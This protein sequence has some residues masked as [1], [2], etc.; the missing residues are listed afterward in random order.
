MNALTPLALTSE[1]MLRTINAGDFA[2][3][4]DLA[5]KSGRDKRHI[6]RDLAILE[7]GGL[8]LKADGG[9]P[10][11][12]DAG[13]DQL[14][15]IERANTPLVLHDQ[16][17]PDP[18]NPRRVFHPEAL[19]ALAESIYD[20][21]K[22]TLLQPPVIR[23][24]EGGPKPYRLVAGERRW[25]AIG[26]LI[27]DGRWPATTPVPVSIRPMSDEEAAILALVENMQREDLSPVDEAMTFEHLAET[28]G[29]S[30][31]DIAKHIKR[32]PEYVQQRRRV[33]KLPADI[34]ARMRLPK[35]DENHIGF[36]EAR[37]MFTVS[38]EPERPKTPQ[39]SPKLAL[40]LL[41]LAHKIEAAPM[42]INGETG[43]T[44]LTQRPTGGALATLNDR[45]IVL[46]REWSGQVF[47]KIQL[48]TS[49]AVTFLE[50]AGFY[51]PKRDEVIWTARTAIMSPHRASEATRGGRYITPEL[52]TEL[53]P[54][55]APEA[56][57][58]DADA[59]SRPN[60]R[61]VEIAAV[62][63]T[64]PY[65]SS[66]DKIN[67]RLAADRKKA[68]DEDQARM[69]LLA[70]GIGD[71]FESIVPHAKVA[72]SKYEKAQSTGNEELA[73]AASALLAACTWKLNGGTHFGCE[74]GD[75]AAGPRIR[76]ALRAPDGEAPLWGIEGRFVLLVD[77][78]MAG[79]KTKGGL[80][81]GIDFHI[82]DLAKPFFSSTGYRS[83][84]FRHGAL[85]TQ[86]GAPLVV[87][88][89]RA[90]RRLVAEHASKRKPE[91][92][93]LELAGRALERETWIA[94]LIAAGKVIDGTAAIEE[95]EARVAARPD[96]VETNPVRGDTSAARTL[97]EEWA[98]DIMSQVNK[99]LADIWEEIESRPTYVPSQTHLFILA[100]KAV[101]AV[102]TGDIPAFLALYG[103]M[104]T[105][106]QPGQ[107]KDEIRKTFKRLGVD[108]R[109]IDHALAGDSPDY[110]EAHR[111]C[112]GMV[113]A[114]EHGLPVIT[115]DPR[116]PV[117]EEDEF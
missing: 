20:D 97:N 74:S 49:G 4:S 30:N 79:V 7:K 50:D 57:D 82:T 22:L 107:V 72:L 17:E 36:K 39:L 100:D 24:R 81:G 47:A 104:L 19:Q 58:A 106:A 25:R 46:L 110:V 77:G 31:A 29:W 78:M 116:A 62:A 93:D 92:V 28:L 12:T 69:E 66:T 68:D 54:E 2:T 51:G 45:R 55:A 117:D 44:V 80:R 59:E 16:I 1:A 70:A 91:P 94:D 14:A 5:T 76:A 61:G 95:H 85:K 86:D 33:L 21:G 63:P 90:M 67:A 53:A 6:T 101:R 83:E 75:D 109:T 108:G 18:L 113:T 56:D 42:I 40:A 98:E 10:T 11:L 114:D 38:K 111:D 3:L 64:K 32:V 99:V 89:A 60:N 41:E 84:F 65:V 23:P 27:A 71:D 35:S 105:A 102:F 26:L 87:E 37:K 34:Q 112:H 103:R 88:V 13:L 48:Y 115:D 43:F 15:A 96:P 9:R 73:K 8:I 52:N